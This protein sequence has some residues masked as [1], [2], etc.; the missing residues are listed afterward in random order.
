[1]E[2]RRFLGSVAGVG[3]L[4]TMASVALAAPVG[5]TPGGMP[6]PG[7]TASPK[8]NWRR[9]DSK[10]NKNIREIRKHLDKVIDELQHDQHDYAGH[11][12]KALDLLN[13]ARQELLAAEQSAQSTPA[14]TAH[15]G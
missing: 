10:S 9:N 6:S 3:A 4:L 1:M 12:E 7:P 5:S 14:P 13:R 2:R 8:H 15:P 11:R